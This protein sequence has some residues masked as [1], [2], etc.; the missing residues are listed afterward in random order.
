MS[1]ISHE[2][3]WTWRRKG[4]LNRET[5]SL[6]I[7][8]QNNAIRTNYIKARVD[9]SQQNSKCGLCDDRKETTNRMISEYSKLAQNECKSTQN[10]ISKVIH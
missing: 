8:A 7:A 10:R 3:T 4:N 5:E 2:K 1:N 6:L 9:K